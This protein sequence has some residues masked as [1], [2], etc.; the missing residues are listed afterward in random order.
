MIDAGRLVFM[1][2]AVLDRHDGRP[3]IDRRIFH[4]SQIFKA[5]SKRGRKVRA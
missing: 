5:P 2:D 3:F 1:A 4:V